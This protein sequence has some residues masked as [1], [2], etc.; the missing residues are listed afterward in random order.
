MCLIISLSMLNVLVILEINLALN[1]PRLQFCSFWACAW[2]LQGFIYSDDHIMRREEGIGNVCAIFS[3]FVFMLSVAG[4]RS[5]VF[6]PCIDRFLQ[7]VLVTCLLENR[8]FFVQ[9]HN[10]RTGLVFKL[11]FFQRALFSLAPGPWYMD[12]PVGSAIH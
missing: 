11:L 1:A 6:V 5:S 3:S 10:L 9:L 7:L 4:C 2:V 12:R 8:L